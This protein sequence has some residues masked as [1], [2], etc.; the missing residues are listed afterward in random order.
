MNIY[1]S[2]AD[3]DD[4]AQGSALS[5]AIQGATSG[6]FFGP[7]G[8]II[9]G[10]LGLFGAK[11]SNA[12]SL[13]MAREQM[14]FQERMSNTAHQREVADLRAAGLNPILS[15]QKGAS[16]PAGAMAQFENVG[17]SSAKSAQ[18]TSLITAQ[19][20]NM[21]AQTQQAQSQSTLNSALAAKANAETITEGKRP[22][23]I[24]NQAFEAD[25]RGLL[26]HQGI[27]TQAA[28]TVLM[29]AQEKLATA[30]ASQIPVIIEHTREQIKQLARE[31]KINYNEAVMAATVFERSIGKY[32][33][34]AKDA[35]GALEN[36]LPDWSKIFKSKKK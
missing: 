13:A 30:Q 36:L 35:T 5:G 22:D 2:V 11:K 18:A 17:E 19:L 20:A 24:K 10:A 34:T 32:V 12:S 27:R 6:S 7:I 21:E 31:N 25:A 33:S 9:G 14:A 8:S 28:Q 23:L 29:S 3:D 15:A 16:T 26:H 1:G 4:S